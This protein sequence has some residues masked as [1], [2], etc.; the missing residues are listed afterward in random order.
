M[1]YNKFVGYW[2]QNLFTYMYGGANFVFWG[3]Q[4]YSPP[5][6][7]SPP[8]GSGHFPQYGHERKAAYF[9]QLRIWDDQNFVSPDGN[10][11]QVFSNR[12]DCYDAQV[13]HDGA[14][15]YPMAIFYGGP[16]QCKF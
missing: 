9:K 14:D 7:P 16:G 1:F 8:M 4:V 3:G 13:S 6:E 2:P 5:N 11:F 15:P 12:P 10:L